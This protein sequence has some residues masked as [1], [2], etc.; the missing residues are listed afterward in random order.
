MRSRG[1]KPAPDQLLVCPGANVM[2]YYAAMCALDPGDE[3][4][5]PD[6]GFVSYFSILEFLGMKI[7]RVPLYEEN[8]FRLA[9]THRNPSQSPRD[10]TARHLTRTERIRE[11]RGSLDSHR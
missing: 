5:V 11:P 10:E 7:V 3:V 1:F 2:I 9:A 8:E 4:I 6:P